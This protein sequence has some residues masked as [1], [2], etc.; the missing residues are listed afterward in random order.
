MKLPRI[1]ILLL[2]LSTEI[3]A[4]TLYVSGMF[5]MG[6]NSGPMLFYN[7]GSTTLATG[8]SALIGVP[9]YQQ[10]INIELEY[11]HHATG[12]K[13][14][15]SNPIGSFSIN[16]SE[17]MPAIKI[18]FGQTQYSFYAKLGIV[19]DFGGMVEQDRIF[20]VFDSIPRLPDPAH[21]EIFYTTA[22]TQGKM[23]VGATWAL[24]YNFKLTH[25]LSVFAEMNYIGF[26]WTATHA[27]VVESTNSNLANYTIEQKQTD[28]S[29]SPSIYHYP[30][31]PSQKSVPANNFSNIGVGVGLTFYFGKGL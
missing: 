15:G 22:I 6:A 5:G 2:L 8:F 27:E 13:Q 26:Q 18:F 23:A 25:Q 1:L 29:E 11:A 12:F 19:L 21:P 3:N 17:L 30:S 7:P 4:Q 9:V 31:Q 16:R 28:Y 24:G 14:G 20:A 10:K